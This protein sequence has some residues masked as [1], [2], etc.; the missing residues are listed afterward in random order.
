MVGGDNVEVKEETMVDIKEDRVDEEEVKLLTEKEI[1][2]I[3]K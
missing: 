3:K 1:Q 2:S